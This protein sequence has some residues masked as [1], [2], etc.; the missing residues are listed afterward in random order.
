M[1]SADG[2]NGGHGTEFEALLRQVVHDGDSERSAACNA[3]A[4]LVPTLDELAALI[5]ENRD[6]EVADVFLVSLRVDTGK[7]AAKQATAEI[8]ER[9]DDG[10]P[11]EQ[12]RTLVSPEEFQRRLEAIAGG[13]ALEL[14]DSQRYHRGRRPESEEKIVSLLDEALEN[15]DEDLR[16]EAF[17]LLWEWARDLANSECHDFHAA[18][19]LASEAILRLL[20]STEKGNPS[21]STSEQPSS[22]GDA[23]VL[24]GVEV[25]NRVYT[26]LVG[27]NTAAGKQWPSLTKKYLADRAASRET[28]FDS[29][30]P[31][32]DGP[33]RDDRIPDHRPPPA[34]ADEGV[35][36]APDFA[37]IRRALTGCRERLDAMT[38]EREI[39]RR[40]AEAIGVVLEVLDARVAEAQMK[41]ETEIDLIVATIT[42]R[43]V[44]EQNSVLPMLRAKLNK[45]T[46][47]PITKRLLEIKDQL[48]LNGALDENLEPR[49]AALDDLSPMLE[50]L[51]EVANRPEFQKNR[52]QR[53]TLLAIIEYWN[54]D[55]ESQRSSPA[56]TATTIRLPAIF[57]WRQRTHVKEDVQSALKRKLGLSKTAGHN[58]IKRNVDVLAKWGF[59]E[60]I[61][62]G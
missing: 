10:E 45:V 31:H 15:A 3:L 25:V 12:P 5:K 56:P 47:Q 17:E 23:V 9:Q 62:D 2:P 35:A 39:R 1:P 59:V 44:V 8:V 61:S 41:Q 13:T 60:E 55:I 46:V 11:P 34:D 33:I 20:H 49:P 32:D 22:D 6:A 7:H 16:N 50:A 4:S 42:R 51:R 26:S 57:E 58:L 37:R 27:G 30:S 38:K 21:G 19:D 14:Y 53:E 48:I 36:I 29:A 24:S 40:T 28:L 43:C 52:R 54:T 18:A